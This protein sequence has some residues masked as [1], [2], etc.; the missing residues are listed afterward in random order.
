[1]HIILAIVRVVAVI[2]VFSSSAY[3]LLC[4]WSAARFL[5][6][7]QAASPAQASSAFPP[8]SILKPLKGIDPEIYESFRS[9]CVQDYPE[10][11]IIFGV[12]DPNDPAIESVK[13]LQKEFPQLAI[14]LLVCQE[15]LGTNV[16]VSNLSQMVNIA[17]FDHLIV[18]DSD[19][20]V[21]PDYLQRIIAPL[22]DSKIG[23]VT[24]LYRGVAQSTMGSRLESL[25]ISTDFCAGVLAARQLQ[26]GIRFGLG[27]TLAFRR[28]E[29]EKIGGFISVVD[30]L[31]DDYELGERIASLGLKV[32]LSDVVVETFLP[33]YRFK[34]FC[35]HQLRWARGMRDARAGGYLG[36]VSTF[37]IAW[38]L[39]AL[40]ASRAS[41][42]SCAVLAFTLLLRLTVAITVGASV[43]H[44]RQVLRDAWLI[45]L[46]DLIAVAVWIASLGGNTVTWRGERFRLSKGRLTRISN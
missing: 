23:M 28:G 15:I 26:G 20:R 31:A 44:D 40:A 21:Q 37:G 6:E 24:C 39:V 33:P 8:V 42:W 7:R 13:M 34:D 10:Y 43:L 41:A 9:H 25:G 32:E 1:M 38:A 17:R 11:E 12:S 46:R 18:N 14:H 35:A 22:T 3:Y 5:R 16:K 30:Y 19:I 27:S 4:L 45:P 29:L 2:G 36:L